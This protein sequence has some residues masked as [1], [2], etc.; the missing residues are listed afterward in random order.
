M[1]VLYRIL[2]YPNALLI[3]VAQTVAPGE[4]RLA[5]RLK[6]AVGHGGALYELSCAADQ[7]RAADAGAGG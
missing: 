2:R 1:L 4:H 3:P 5:D 7:R 6:G